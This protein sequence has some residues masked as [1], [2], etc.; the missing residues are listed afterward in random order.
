MYA[1]SRD[2]AKRERI[3]A[4]GAH[5]AFEPGARLPERV[6]VVIETVGAATFDHS[7]KSPPRRPDRGLRRDLRPNPPADLRRV[8]SMQL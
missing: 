5:A 7:L 4:L 8:F 6:D 1:T 2:A 3:V